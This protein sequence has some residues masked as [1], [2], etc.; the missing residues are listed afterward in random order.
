MKT[1]IK[2]IRIY[3]SFN[4]DEDRIEAY[5]T[6]FVIEIKRYWFSRWKIRDYVDKKEGKVKYYK[7]YIEAINHL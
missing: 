1:R 3:N 4:H 5:T 2:V 7:S 6:L